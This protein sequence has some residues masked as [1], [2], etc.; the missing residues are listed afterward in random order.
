[1]IYLVII[2]L[3]HHFQTEFNESVKLVITIFQHV[4]MT[5]SHWFHWAR[6]HLTTF[7]NRPPFN[8]ICFGFT[9]TV[10]HCTQICQSWPSPVFFPGSGQ[11]DTAYSMT[12]HH[13]ISPCCKHHPPST[14]LRLPLSNP[15]SRNHLAHSQSIKN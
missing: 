3:N 2:K 13:D 14:L 10:V 8:F 4:L 12:F 11:L 9:S 15:L 1:M 7:P 5:V 6:L